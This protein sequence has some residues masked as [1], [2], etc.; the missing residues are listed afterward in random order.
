MKALLRSLTGALCI[1][2]IYGLDL[3]VG[4]VSR[5]LAWGVKPLTAWAQ[6][7]ERKATEAFLEERRGT[8]VFHAGLFI[9]VG[10]LLVGATALTWALTQL[11][12]ATAALANKI[13]SRVRRV[14]P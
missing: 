7:L 2:I 12:R 6:S 11:K 9:V 4:A 8:C 3:L 5:P 10:T 14:S 13:S 1:V